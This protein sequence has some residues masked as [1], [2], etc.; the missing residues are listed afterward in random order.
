ME[1]GK[2]KIDLDLLLK[3]ANELKIIVNNKYD[4]L[5][6]AD[7]VY[8]ANV[9][10]TSD[11]DA[12]NAPSHLTGTV[13]DGSMTWTYIR[14]RTDGAVIA[15]TTNSLGTGY[16]QGI[17]TDVPLKSNNSGKDLVLDVTVCVKG[18]YY[19]HLTLPTKA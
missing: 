17:Y 10:G 5:F 2:R 18:V 3:I 16:N 1:S 13:T 19:T 8:Q 15:T 11:S 4:L 14:R 9:T 12:N 6:V 7:R